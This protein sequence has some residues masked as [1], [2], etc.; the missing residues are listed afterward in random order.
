M[1]QVTATQ[2]AAPPAETTTPAASAGDV[3]SGISAIL[4]APEG[5]ETQT[6][7]GQVGEL[8]QQASQT[9]GLEQAA[10]DVL[11]RA[12]VPAE[13]QA[14]ELP[15][16]EVDDDDEPEAPAP[17][18]DQPA[19]NQ[20]PGKSA[21]RNA[22]Y[23]WAKQIAS[24]YHGQELK[25]VTPDQL[26]SVDDFKSM[27][28]AQNKLSSIEFEFNQATPQ[29][30][31]S[32]LEKLSAGNPQAMTQFASNMVRVLPQTNPDAY[33]AISSPIIKSLVNGF[34]SRA[35]QETNLENKQALGVAA[36]TFEYFVTGGR[37]YRQ[38]PYLQAGE[39]GQG[40]QPQAGMTP[41]MQQIL[42]QNQQ[43]QQMIQKANEE[44]QAAAYNSRME[45][46]N[47]TVSDE[48][49]KAVQE[50][51]APLAASY[52]GQ[53]K[54]LEALQQKFRQDVEESIQ[55]NP[56]IHRFVQ[57]RELA[58]AQGNEQAKQAALGRLKAMLSAAV[59]AHK[60]AYFRS[61]RQQMESVHQDR[62]EQLRQAAEVRHPAPA[63][64]VPGASRGPIDI[65]QVK[66]PREGIRALLNG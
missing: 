8:L 35:E 11:D 15:A 58:V 10:A 22:A 53:P 57:D 1:D 51:L 46:M 23:G 16:E 65:S 4:N 62:H 37:H 66:S 28:E 34:Y 31:W 12:A 48:I 56:N 29:A 41:E 3:R 14:E 61:S 2:G 6:I 27:L 18:G 17:G 36:Q 60:P 38:L 19:Q 7:A 55:A 5:G 44:A 13:T 54:L 63:A 42:A 20:P 40:Q 59:A 49:G 43:Y 45:Q 9:S 21:R 64:S 52:K 24:A 33:R 39:N 25:T 47:G 30:H 32:V 50:A 26:P